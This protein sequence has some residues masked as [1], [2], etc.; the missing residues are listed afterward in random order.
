MRRVGRTTGRATGRSRASRRRSGRLTAR[1]RL[2]R[3]A[4]GT[5]LGQ[6]GTT[7]LGGALFFLIGPQILGARRGGRVQSFGL[8]GLFDPRLLPR[9]RFCR[10]G[11]ALRFLC[12]GV[13]FALRGFLA[14]VF[15]ISLSAFAVLCQARVFFLRFLH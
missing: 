9:R 3:F 10:L 7:L 6:L 15:E 1:T 2:A 11:G 5:P 13:G 12:L 14:T 4:F 8:R